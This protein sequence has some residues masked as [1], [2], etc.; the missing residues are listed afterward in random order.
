MVHLL[1]LVI[2][3]SVIV[4][5]LLDGSVYYYF[6]GR[7]SLSVPLLWGIYSFFLGL[8]SISHLLISGDATL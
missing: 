3:L 2:G 4:L 8:L 5:F 1:L 7:I 6:L